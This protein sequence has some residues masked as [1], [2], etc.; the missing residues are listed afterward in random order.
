M[1]TIPISTALLWTRGMCIKGSA[2]A[3]RIDSWIEY[4]LLFDLFSLC[5]SYCIL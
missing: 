4:P 3:N 1:S 2:S 5:L